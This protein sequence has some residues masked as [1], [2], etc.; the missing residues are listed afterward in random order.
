LKGPSVRSTP[1]EVPGTENG[2]KA[3]KVCE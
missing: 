2:Q 3:A 1:I